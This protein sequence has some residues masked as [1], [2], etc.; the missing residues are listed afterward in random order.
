M[1]S[2]GHLACTVMFGLAVTVCDSN[3]PPVPGDGSDDCAVYFVD[4]EPTE[5]GIWKNYVN[6]RMSLLLTTAVVAP[7]RI[8]IDDKYVYWTD[9]G[10][11]GRVPK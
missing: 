7:N 10:F 5:R 4:N 9:Q 11:I 1:T 8:A 6:V 3:A 2:R